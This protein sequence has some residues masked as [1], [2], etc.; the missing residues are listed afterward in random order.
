LAL[1]TWETIRAS[2]FIP[3]LLPLQLQELVLPIART[4][5][6]L[7]NTCL[8]LDHLGPLRELK[9]RTS[10]LHGVH[11]RVHIT[12]HHGLGVAAQGILQEVSQLGLAVSDVLTLLG[13]RRV[14]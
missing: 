9:G 4:G 3:R 7:V 10:L 1:G 13:G 11:M 12:D 6:L 5:I 14:I 2:G 8:T